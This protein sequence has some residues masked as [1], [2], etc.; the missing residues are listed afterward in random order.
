[1]GYLFISFLALILRIKFMKIM[2]ELYPFSEQGKA[3]GLVGGT[4]TLASPSSP[5]IGG[6]LLDIFGWPALFLINIHHGVY[7]DGSSLYSVGLLL[8]LSEAGEK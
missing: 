7:D 6:V 4:V 5:F 8:S 1:M 2:V 3:M